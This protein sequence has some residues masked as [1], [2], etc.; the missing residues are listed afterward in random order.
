[1]LIDQIRHEPCQMIGR[2]P[3]IQRRRQQQPLARVERPK[4]LACAHRLDL[5]LPVSPLDAELLGGEQPFLAHD[6][7]YP[8]EP[9]PSADL[10]WRVTDPRS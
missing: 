5:A 10:N 3:V 7:N 1:M 9:A 2:K 6:D 8:A 4:C